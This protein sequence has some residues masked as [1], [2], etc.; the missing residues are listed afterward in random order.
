[1]ETA[2]GHCH[3]FVCTPCCI[4][5]VCAA[6]RLKSPKRSGCLLQDLSQWLELLQAL[7]QGVPALC[8]WGQGGTS[9]WQFHTAGSVFP[10]EP[11]G[12]AEG[13]YTVS[14]LFS[15]V[16]VAIAGR[17]LSTHKQVQMG[18]RLILVSF[19]YAARVVCVVAVYDS[20]CPNAGLSEGQV[21]WY[22]FPYTRS[23]L[24][25]LFL[26]KP[27]SL[28]CSFPPQDMPASCRSCCS[29]SASVQVSPALSRA[30]AQ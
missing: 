14:D 10:W 18:P 3:F 1:M 2:P 6:F 12:K 26:C 25:L 7:G 11:V 8:C 27:L 20:V 15:S 29:F 16:H 24:P 28:T 13:L 4:P 9:G 21:P 30:Q 22:S 19:Y 17:G 23:R 5:C